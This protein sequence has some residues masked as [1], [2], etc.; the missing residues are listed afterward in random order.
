MAMNR[1]AR[2]T[3]KIPREIVLL[4][5]TPCVW[6][7]CTFCDYIDDNTT[8]LEEIRRV[9]DRELAKITGEFNRL[10]VINSGSIQELPDDVLETIRSVIRDRGITE[11]YCES[12]WSYRRRY[13]ETR[14]FFGVPT[15]IKL[16]VETFD[17]HL[18]N[19]VLNKAMH[20]DSPQ[21]VARYTDAICLM[22]GLKGQT[23]DIIA[24]DV[25]ILVAHFSYGCVNVFAPNSKSEGLLDQNI[26]D[27]FRDEYAWLD[28]QANVE[29]MLRN[30]DYG[31]G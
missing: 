28:E 14:E 8:D 24:R 17:D 12:Y 20:F 23:H 16:G 9:A 7:R 3:R 21:E 15:R 30:T 13:D 19:V 11:F 1:Y 31:V 10:E 25:D 22:V 4:K 6:G 5:S 29:L 18:R 26:I 27:W 2:I